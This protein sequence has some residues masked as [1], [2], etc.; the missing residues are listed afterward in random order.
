ME[1]NKRWIEEVLGKKIVSFCYSR[2]GENDAIVDLVKAVGYKYAAAMKKKMRPV[3]TDPYRIHRQIIPRGM[4]T[5]KSGLLATRGR[6][7]I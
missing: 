5:W 2:G 3:G 1:D 6:W 4:E 7:K